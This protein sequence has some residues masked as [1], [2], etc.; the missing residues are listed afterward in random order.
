ML[1]IPGNIIRGA[2]SVVGGTVSAVA[3]VAGVGRK[4]ELPGDIVVKEKTVITVKVTLLSFVIPFSLHLMNNL[5]VR[6]H[7]IKMHKQQQVY[8][9]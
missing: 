3:S 6:K 5:L 9:S 4:S 7:Q 1:N 8:P 2:G